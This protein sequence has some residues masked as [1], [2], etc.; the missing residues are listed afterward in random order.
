MRAVILIVLAAIL[1]AFFLFDLDSYFT[2]EYLKGQQAALQQLV[3]ERPLGSALAYFGV[4]VT[5]ASLSLP[6]ASLLTLLGGALF[7]LL[8]GTVLVSFASTIGASVAF[9]FA[10]YFFRDVVENRFGSRL[11]AIN[12]GIDKEGAFYLF[13]IRLIPVIPYFVVNLLMGLT[14]IPLRIFFIAS[15][16]GMLPATLVYVNAGTQLASLKTPSD[17]LSAPLILSF[18]ALGVLPLIAKRLVDWHR[19]NAVLKPYSKPARFDRNL[20]VIGAGSGGLVSAY[21]AAAIEA[22]VS[23]VEKSKMGGDCLNYGCVPSK[24][25]I[26]CAKA[27]QQARHSAKFGVLVDAPRVDFK[28][29]MQHV[30]HSIDAIAPHDS[31]ERYTSLGVECLSGEAR[32]VDPYRVEINGEIL[33]TRNIILATGGS[34]AVPDLPGLSDIDFLT[35]DNVWELTELPS[36]LVVLGGG[37]IGCELSQA[38]ARLGSEVTLVQRGNRLLPREDADVSNLVAERF[39]EEGIRILTETDTLEIDTSNG[40][41]VLRG[42]DR[43][44]G[45]EVSVGFDRLLLATGRKA[46]S[47]AAGVSELGIETRDDGTIKTDRYLRTNLPTVYA[48]GDVTGPYQFTHAASHQAWYATVNALFAG[49]KKFAVDYRVIPWCTFTDPEVARVG[50]NEQQAKQQGVKFEVTRYGIDDLDRAITD[51]VAHG[52]VKVLTVPGKDKILGATIVGEHAGELLAEFVLAMKNN[53]GLNKI[54]ATIHSYPTLAEANK[55][56]AGNWR[57]AHKPAWAMRLLRRFHQWRLG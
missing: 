6:G 26:R 32:V 9:L 23:L 8:W 54:L 27:A 7:G 11:K 2:L 49:F 25:L 20:I 47:D 34:P 52:F 14:K 13:S 57:R 38:F 36:R 1:A 55:Y 45:D 40:E 12:E 43:N 48:C 24:A 46:R 56:T 29:A 50:L 39:H 3:A 41:T 35:S 53:L 44:S 5:M 28:L 21:I 51:G 17:I 16:I 33:S 31:V 18:V 30:K 19:R 37:P 22:N 42:R 10:R 4:Y 15:Q